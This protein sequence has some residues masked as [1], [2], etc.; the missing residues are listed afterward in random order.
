MKNQNF[1]TRP[2][3]KKL[4]GIWDNIV[5][6]WRKIALSNGNLIL[7]ITITVTATLS[8]GRTCSRGWASVTDLYESLR[9]T[10]LYENRY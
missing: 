3:E 9:R 2:N 5:K 7:T 4:T 10:A 8:N 1:E 6:D